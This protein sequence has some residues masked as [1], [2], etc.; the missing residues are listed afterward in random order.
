[1]PNQFQTL[2]GALVLI[3]DDAPTVR[4]LMI[5]LLEE[6]GAR[7]IAASGLQEALMLLQGNRPDL[8][9]CSLQLPNGDGFELLAQIHQGQE[10][11]NLTPAIAITNWANPAEEARALTLGFQYYFAKPVAFETLI[12]IAAQLLQP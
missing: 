6:V 10:P 8:L 2:Q 4:A 3:V 1:M 12:A 11:G 9:I 7:V 5:M